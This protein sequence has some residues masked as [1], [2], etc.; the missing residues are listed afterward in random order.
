MADIALIYNNDTSRFDIALDGSD[1]QTDDGLRTAVLLSLFCDASA[2]GDE[3]QMDQKDNHRGWWADQ[4]AIIT[5]E[6][7]GSLLWLLDRSKRSDET[8]T[9]AKSYIETA[10]QW[11][12][13]DGVVERVQVDVAW[14]SSTALAVAIAMRRPDGKVV[15]FRFDNLWDAIHAYL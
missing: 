6:R 8:A 9:L 4:Y 12:V 11:A 13:D 10:L 14:I 3:P 1:L 15:D 2:Q 5:G 7:F